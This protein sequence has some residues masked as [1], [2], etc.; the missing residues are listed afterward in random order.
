MNLSE[1]YRLNRAL[2]FEG[3]PQGLQGI[4]CAL[5]GSIIMSTSGSE[6]F[7]VQDIDKYVNQ[8]VNKLVTFYTKSMNL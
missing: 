1:R 7:S 2:N 3:K 6:N 5:N 4:R 8:A